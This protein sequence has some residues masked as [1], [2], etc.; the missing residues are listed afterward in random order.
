MLNRFQILSLIILSLLFWLAAAL[1]VRLAPGALTDPTRC[2][3]AF[4]TTM[5]VGWLSVVLT[6][7]VGGLSTEQLIP[8]VAVVGAAAMMIDGVALRWMPGIYGGNDTV[9]RLEAAWLL[10]GYGTSL[11]IALVMAAR[12]RRPVGSA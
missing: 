2:A 9:V 5:P 1:Y 11:A 8:G 7:R 10:W 4:A 12:A 6:R 3:I